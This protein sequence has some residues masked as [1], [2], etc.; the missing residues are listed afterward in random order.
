VSTNQH[1]FF[2]SGRY[3]WS[4]RPEEFASVQAQLHLR[5]KEDAMLWGRYGSFSQSILV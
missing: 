4:E 1:S 5:G 3:S 2:L